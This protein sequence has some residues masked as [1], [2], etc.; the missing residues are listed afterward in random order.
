M[1]LTFFRSFSGLSLFSTFYVFIITGVGARAGIP[2][3]AVV[4]ERL[5][6]SV[7]SQIVLSSDLRDFR[8]SIRLRSQIDPIFAS[9][10]ISKKAA[11]ALDSDILDYLINERI[12]LQQFPIADAEV[13]QSIAEIQAGNKM[14][15][16]ALK[17]AL[18]SEGF[19]FSDYFEL[20][21]ASSSK[22]A[23]IEREIRSKVTITDDDLKNEFLN[24][25]GSSGPRSYN[26]KMI[27]VATKNFK[28]PQAARDVLA[29]ALSEIRGGASFEE[30]SKKVSDTPGELGV[31][32]EDQ[33]SGA[34]R[35]TLKTLKIGEVSEIVASNDRSHFDIFK[36]VDVKTGDQDIFLKQ[37]E[38]IR[39]KLMSQEYQ[40]Q[41]Q[42]WIERQRQSAFVHKRGQPT[43]AGVPTEL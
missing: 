5:E 7:N 43:L 36:L 41:I 8:R 10:E 19:E 3:N 13:E 39:A 12:I 40:R 21:R 30:V 33:L 18:Q 11:Q 35:E 31:L 23:L 25:K 15:R 2:E 6:A 27:S 28:S 22:R 38:E 9:T 37:K 17:T 4:L 32:T 16:T 42:L 20:I 34:L 29:Q 1:K 26:L 24:S 14:D